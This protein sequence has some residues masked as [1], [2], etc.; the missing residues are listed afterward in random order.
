MPGGRG[1]NL[2]RETKKSN[3]QETFIVE[4]IVVD[5]GHWVPTYTT[6][7]GR[8]IKTKRPKGTGN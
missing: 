4:K 6:R 8:V 1:K 2:T 5:D 7:Y 3:E